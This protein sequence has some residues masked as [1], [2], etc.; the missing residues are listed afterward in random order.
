VLPG[1]G[2]VQPLRR[3]DGK[4]DAARGRVDRGRGRTSGQHGCFVRVTQ[5][6]VPVDRTQ[7]PHVQPGNGR[8]L[9]GPLPVAHRHY[10]RPVNRT[11][12]QSRHILAKR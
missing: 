9:H 12:L 10:G 3:P 2:C 11:L 6:S 7:V 4:L 5:Q 1:S 8:L